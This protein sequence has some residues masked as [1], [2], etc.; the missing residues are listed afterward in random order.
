MDVLWIW[1]DVPVQVLS[2][3]TT[4]INGDLPDES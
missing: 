1:F 3:I 4:T 2:W